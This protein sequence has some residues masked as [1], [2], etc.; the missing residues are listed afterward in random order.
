[1]FVFGLDFIIKILPESVRGQSPSTQRLPPKM[2][3]T[4]T[5]DCIAVG[6]YI[7]IQRQKYTKLHKYGSVESTAVLGKDVI[8]LRNIAGQPY[9]T[10]FRMTPKEGGG[11]RGKK[12]MTL[13]PCT[14]TVRVTSEVLGG[15]E[16]GADNRNI[17]DDGQSQALNA[18]EIGKLR[19]D[20]KS[21]TEIVSQIVENS[22]TFLSKTEYSQAKYLKKKEK[23]YYEY[24][25][26][27][28]TNVRLV[29]EVMFRQCPEKILGMRMDTLSQLISYSGVSAVGNHLL[30]E[31]GTN[32]LIPAALL[33]SIGAGTEGR[34]VHLHPGNVPQKQA[35]LA[36]NLPQEQLD[37]CTSVN[38][39]SVLRQFYQCNDQT[40]LENTASGKKRKIDESESDIS[41]PAKMVKSSE[42]PDVEIELSEV[43]YTA[44]QQTDATPPKRHQWQLDNDRACQLLT[45]KLDSLVIC[46]KEHPLEIVRA[47]LPFVHPSRPFVVFNTSREVLMELYVAL[48]SSG[49]VT[50]L[51]ITSN[52]LRMYQIL[53]NRTH[54][55]VNMSGSGGFLL[56]GY[57]I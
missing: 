17:V 9:A 10:T 57:T 22:S 51:R 53:P 7:V 24:V 49:D 33:N 21:A 8:E 35:L 47:L 19:D 14:D 37:R 6:D 20:G 12:P 38:I 39:Y 32:G 48:K 18:A 13:E 54:P 45:N 56:T 43:V 30:Y 46:A 41:P 1:M 2:P 16:C 44:E 27:K 25:Q 36:L 23:K 31:S 50:N 55:D 11:G 15:A 52:W 40:S 28:K 3:P 34:L 29:T 26:I 4:S 5:E 42:Q